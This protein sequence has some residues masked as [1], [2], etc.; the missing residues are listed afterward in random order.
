MTDP[1]RFPLGTMNFVFTVYV[2]MGIPHQR[3][4]IISSDQF[5]VNRKIKLRHI[6]QTRRSNFVQY[7]CPIEK[8]LQFGCLTVIYLCYPMPCIDFYAPSPRPRFRRK[9]SSPLGK[10]EMRDFFAGDCR[11]RH[12]CIHTS[13]TILHLDRIATDRYKEQGCKGPQA[14]CEKYLG[15]GMGQRIY[16]KHEIVRLFHRRLAEL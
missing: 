10:G 7:K 9:R 2:R 12:P 3:R 8:G 11:P 4:L 14:P 1:F 16:T 13:N 15:S 6:A 5:I